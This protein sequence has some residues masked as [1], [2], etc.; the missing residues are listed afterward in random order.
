MK[1]ITILL[2]LLPFA[3]QAQMNRKINV[4]HFDAQTVNLSLKPA[5]DLYGLRIDLVR[6]TREVAVN[7]STKEEIEEDNRLIGFN[8]GDFLF[9]DLNFNLSIRV[10][11]LMNLA[12]GSDFKLKKSDWPHR[13][14]DDV[15]YQMEEGVFSYSYREKSRTRERFNMEMHDGIV[16]V[17][18]K[19]RPQFQLIENEEGLMKKNRWSWDDRIYRHEPDFYSTSKNPKRGYRFHQAGDQVHLHKTFIVTTNSAGDALEIYHWR[20]NRLRK[21]LYSIRYNQNEI[22]VY[23]RRHKGMIINYSPEKVEVLNKRHCQ[24]RYQ[25][26]P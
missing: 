22:I 11:H 7:D 20:K 4:A 12:P 25:R 9:M 24:L 14:T 3:L 16:E 13:R 5:Y 21:P 1:T 23:N 2:L 26:L 10:D 15:F 6:Q 18:Y 19:K 17:Y 8:I